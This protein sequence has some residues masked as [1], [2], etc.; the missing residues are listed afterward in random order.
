MRFNHILFL[1]FVS[2]FIS[3]MNSSRTKDQSD[4][5]Q[6][7]IG[8]KNLVVQ[9][10]VQIVTFIYHRFGDDRY[11]ST[12]IGTNNFQKQ[13]EY[14]KTHDFKV[15]SWSEALKELRKPGKSGR[16]VVITIDDAFKSFYQ[17]GLPLLKKYGY[18]ATLFIN[19]ETIG[20]DSY[21]SW[22]E[23]RESMKEG[24]EIGN[25]T[26]SHAFFLNLPEEER[27]KKF[28]EEIRRSQ[29][30]IGEN[31]D[32]YVPDVFAYPYGEFDEKMQKIV[33]EEGMKAAMAQNS[34]VIDSGTD[35]YALPRFP[36]SSYYSDL[37]AFIEKANMRPLKIQ[38]IYPSTHLMNNLKNPPTLTLEILKDNLQW[39]SLQC[40]VQGG[41]CVLSVS[42]DEEKVKLEIKGDKALDR[43]RTLYTVTVKDSDGSWHWFSHLWIM[44]EYN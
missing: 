35:L 39:S 41:K 36:M 11:P 4:G 27:Y 13:L 38:T 8:D 30:L 32:D 37:S 7:E 3:C 1:L 40:F 26:H 31:L 28:R 20:G 15:I 2:I 5:G 14:L 21:M 24:I 23:I 9:N 22:G 10:E 18:P 42:Q 43:R 17:N 44:S 29:K 34:G 25:H 33:R 16:F 6:K 19:T 12:N